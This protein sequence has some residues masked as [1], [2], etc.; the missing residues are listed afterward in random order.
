MRFPVFE[1][2]E[3]NLFS[4][5]RFFFLL[6][7]QCKSRF[8]Q[9]A[10]WEMDW[11]RWTNIEA[12]ALF[13]FVAVWLFHIEAYQIKDIRSSIRFYWRAQK[14]N[15][16]QSRQK[17]SRNFAKRLG[18]HEIL[19][20]LIVCTTK[21][22]VSKTFW[23][24]QNSTRRWLFKSKSFKTLLK[25]RLGEWIHF[26]RFFWQ[27]VLLCMWYFYSLQLCIYFWESCSNLNCYWRNY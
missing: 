4:T 8:R 5:R 18:T 23:T 12:H 6:F 17:Q 15:Q 26:E 24:C 16:G 14:R 3:K 2:Y 9:K 22:A 20:K 27:P 10:A 13:Q 25:H 19:S 1:I 11:H 7:Q 21:G